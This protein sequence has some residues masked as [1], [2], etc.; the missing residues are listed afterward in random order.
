MTLE[1]IFD[2]LLENPNF[3]YEGNGWKVTSKE[4]SDSS[5]ISIE[6]KEPENEIDTIRKDFYKWADTIDDDLWEDTCISISHLKATSNCIDSDNVEAVKAA[7]YTFKE[8]YKKVV[9][10]KIKYLQ[11]CLTRLNK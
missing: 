3:E 2:K 4:D 11:A 1:E 7:I 5:F 8:A 9:N 6:Y 10:D